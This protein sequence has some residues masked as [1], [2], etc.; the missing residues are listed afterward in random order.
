MIAARFPTF[1]LWADRIGAWW[2]A[3]QR[4]E[5]VLLILLALV[6]AAALTWSFALR[7]LLETRAELRADAR[8]YRALSLQIA[9]APPGAGPAV[10]APE[11]P[12]ATVAAET[13]AA[14]GL[15]VQGIE[16]DGAGARLSFTAV[17]FATLIAWLD[18]LE[19]RSGVPID[20]L[21]ITRGA[22]PGLVDAH[23]TVGAA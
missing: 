2:A 17:D 23:V 4:R 14:L 9:A 1:A 10:V 22:A 7:P 3:R 8:L 18:A 6:L 20:A 12:P 21:E 19:S 5:R 16:P 15:V 11:G 13:A